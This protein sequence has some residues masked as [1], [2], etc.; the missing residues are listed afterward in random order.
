MVE[1]VVVCNIRRWFLMSVINS[2]LV[3]HEIINNLIFNVILIQSQN[4]TTHVPH[5]KYYTIIIS[6]LSVFCTQ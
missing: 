1:T 3:L 2:M 4:I 6:N 5:V